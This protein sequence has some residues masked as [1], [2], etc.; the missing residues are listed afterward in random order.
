M[1][2]KEQRFA[3]VLPD[4]R[5]FDVEIVARHRIERAKRLVHQQ[6]FGIR[7]QCA[8]D[9]GALAHAAGEFP[10][11]SMLETSEAKPIQQ[12]ERPLPL[13]GARLAGELDRQQHV[14]EDGSPVQQHVALKHHA[15][16]IGWAIQRLAADHDMAR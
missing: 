9:R 6:Q 8:A 7:Q 10:G 14:V 1:R 4:L 2:N 16:P 3:G 12:R 13:V 11:I 5:E 15:E